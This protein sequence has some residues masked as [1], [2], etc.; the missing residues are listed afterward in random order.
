M[1]MQPWINMVLLAGLIA[2]TGCDTGKEKEDIGL[3][4]SA[5]KK[6]AYDIYLKN[7]ESAGDIPTRK[8]RLEQRREEK[9]RLADAILSE[10][11]VDEARINRT[12]EEYRAELVIA[13]YF[14]DLLKE[15][16]SDNVVRAYYDQHQDEF[17][18]ERARF[19]QVSIP[20]GENGLPTKEQAFDLAMQAYGV[21]IRDDF[22]ETTLREQIPSVQVAIPSDSSWIELSAINE[23]LREAV[24]ALEP[25]HVAQPLLGNAEYLVVKLLE[26]VQEETVAFDQARDS[27]RFKLNNEIRLQEKSRLLGELL[28]RPEL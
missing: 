25:N 14:N 5:E 9:R 19:I 13:E 2:I 4:E 12:V 10:G 16:V 27:I 20:F 11:L 18:R 28:E 22:S 1:K 23:T 7:K 15:T 21:L 26:P 24:L 3:S 6:D 17:R 8:E